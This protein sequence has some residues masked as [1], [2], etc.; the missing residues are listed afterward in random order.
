MKLGFFNIFG[1]PMGLGAGVLGGVESYY[2][3]VTRVLGTS[4][5]ALWKLN[6]A[7]GATTAVDSVGGINGTA[8]SVTFG[9]DALVPGGT[10]AAFTTNSY[11]NMAHAA[12]DGLFNELE[13]SLLI[14]MK[15]ATA[16]W[17]DGIIKYAMNFRADVNNRVA[18][19][20]HSG[21]NALQGLYVAGG[22]NKVVTYTTDG[23]ET[24]F[25]VAI[26]YSKSN[27]RV[28]FYF[29]GAQIGA[30]LTGLGVWV[31]ALASGYQNIGAQFAAA[32]AN[33]FVG[34]LANALY[35]PRE[36]TASEVASLSS[37]F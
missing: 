5:Y 6:E 26:T 27:D 1:K 24:P 13:G 10:S 22:T 31:G 15:I 14:W 36:L 17:G 18:I 30:D 21:A 12:M 7:A 37:P 20:K 8:T 16:Q 19:A 4:G 2:Q 34:D 23:R 29:A 9:S 25:V 32:S 11:I 28:R 3:K 33:S 35:V